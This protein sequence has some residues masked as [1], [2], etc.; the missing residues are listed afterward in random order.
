[1]NKDKIQSE[2]LLFDQSEMPM[3]MLYKNMRGPNNMWKS[4]YVRGK[5]PEN[6]SNAWWW[7]DNTTS[8]QSYLSLL[9]G[10]W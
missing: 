7:L 10:N 4:W 5:N 1:L 3:Q 6:T 8:S 9:L 2:K